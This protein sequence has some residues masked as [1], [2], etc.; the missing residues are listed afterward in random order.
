MQRTIILYESRY[1][2]TEVIAKNLSLILGPSKY[3]RIEDFKK[4]DKDFEFF[5][6]GS[7][8]YN[9]KVQLKILKF[10][11]DNIEWIKDKRVAVFC[12]CISMKKEYEYINQLL[13]ILG[14]S[15]VCFRALGGIIQLDKLNLEDYRAIELFCNKVNMPF[16]DIDMYDINKVI[17]FGIEIKNIR[18]DFIKRVPKT[19]LLKGVE[20]FLNAHNTCTLCTSSSIGVR[21]TPIGYSY[22][23]GHIYIITEGG[24][25]FANIILN[26]RVSITIYDNY[27]GMMKLSGMQIA[28]EASI[29]CNNTDEYKKILYLTGIDPDTIKSFSVN[30][31]IIKIKMRKVEFLYSKF[32]NMGYDIKQTYLFN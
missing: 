13:G 28:G 11:E 26:N 20:E 9:E 6:I 16:I 1:G 8:V 27:Q 31:N 10:L 24:E 3:C 14:N 32:K 25:K 4:S 15:V 17:E 21:G 23:D 22:K 5:V 12:T 2:T 18:D 19:Q 29:V 30:M 7:P